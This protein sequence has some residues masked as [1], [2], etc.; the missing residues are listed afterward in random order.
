MMAAVVLG[1][2]IITVTIFV[3]GE[4]LTTEQIHVTRLE[5]VVMS[6]VKVVFVNTYSVGVVNG[7]KQI[8]G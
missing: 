3:T 7:G 6:S 8:C 2:A 5:I 4:L 1:H